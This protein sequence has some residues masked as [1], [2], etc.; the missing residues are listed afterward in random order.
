VPRFVLCP[1]SDVIAVLRLGSRRQSFTPNHGL[2]WPVFPPQ[3]RCDRQPMWSGVRQQSNLRTSP[4]T[5][6][7]TVPCCSGRD[8]VASEHAADF[9]SAPAGVTTPYKEEALKL[10]DQERDQP[11]SRP[12]KAQDVMAP[13]R[14]PRT[15]ASE[16]SREKRRSSPSPRGE[17]GWHPPIAR[18]ARIARGP[19]RAHSQ[20]PGG[21]ALS[22]SPDRTR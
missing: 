15:A 11:Q 6:L 4:R 7:F 17:C 9:H 13:T 16:A 19:S 2:F 14:S 8:V 10:Y 21:N 18:A 1:L 3:D 12:I 5:H 22:H 20:R